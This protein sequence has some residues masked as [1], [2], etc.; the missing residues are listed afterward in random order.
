VTVRDLSL[1]GAMIDENI[2]AANVGAQM[3]LTID[4]IVAELG[5]IV[6]RKDAASTLLSFTL[7]PAAEKVVGEFIQLRRAA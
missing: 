3:M 4:G 5:G 2:A 1:G 6:T 7:T